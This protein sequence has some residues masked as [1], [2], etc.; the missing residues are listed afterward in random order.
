MEKLEKA[1]NNSNKNFITTNGDKVLY[2]CNLS[3]N[4]LKRKENRYIAGD[5]ITIFSDKELRE[6][7][8]LGF[9]YKQLDDIRIMILVLGVPNCKNMLVCPLYFTSNVSSQRSSE[10][11][12]FVGFIDEIS[13][14][15][16]LIA[17]LSRCHYLNMYEFTMHLKTQ[18]DYVLHYFKH[19]YKIVQLDEDRLNYMLEVYTSYTFK[20]N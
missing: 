4:K 1:S 10:H 16:P 15:K 11:E 19:E 18:M 20:R 6:A 2:H 3:K 9:G 8:N 5:I 12:A 17:D 13:R 14:Y 7:K